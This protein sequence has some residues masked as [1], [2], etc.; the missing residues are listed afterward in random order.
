MYIV[1]IV[2]HPLVHDQAVRFAAHTYQE[3]QTGLTNRQYALL[4]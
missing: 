1:F 3:L 4:L 2:I